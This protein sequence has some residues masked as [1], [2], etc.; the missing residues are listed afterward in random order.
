MASELEELLQAKVKDALEDWFH[1]EKVIDEI[2]SRLSKSMESIAEA[3]DS[4]PEQLDSKL[5]DKIASIIQVAENAENE[6]KIAAKNQ[7]EEFKIDTDSIKTE[8]IKSFL[9]SIE[10]EVDSNIKKL[11]LAF[12]KINSIKPEKR[13]SN[14]KI[15]VI[16][17]LSATLSLVG[18]FGGSYLMSTSYQS[19]NLAL[20]A[21]IKGHE[22]SLSV[23]PQ[24]L[25]KKA[26]EAYMKA[27]NN[28]LS[29][30]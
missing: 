5:S 14:K 28:V 6:A 27:A 13:D 11:N 20:K 10:K 18:G 17:L 1:L 2:P 15:I 4:I 3:I 30:N 7:V 12:D 16:G 19:E 23:L 26:D 21:S 29:S 8:I 25:A 9:I 24:A 22:A